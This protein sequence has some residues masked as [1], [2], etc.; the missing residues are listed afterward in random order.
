M[1]RILILLFVFLCSCS[2]RP[3]PGNILTP[4]EM[5]LAMID[6]IKADEYINTVLIKDTTIDKKITRTELYENI[7]QR[8]KTSRK[9]FYDSYTYY[10]QH[11][12]LHKILFDSL[13]NYGNRVKNKLEAAAIDTSTKK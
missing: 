12:D 8:H 4:N 1:S 7:F 10:Q 9:Q 5:K 3:V 13:I 2:S 6:M 11:P